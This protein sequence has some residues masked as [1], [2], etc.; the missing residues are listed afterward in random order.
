[1]II[2]LGFRSIALSM[3]NFKQHSRGGCHLSNWPLL[4]RI[5][6]YVLLLSTKPTSLNISPKPN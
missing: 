2:S 4:N 1:M 3:S 6:P 5:C